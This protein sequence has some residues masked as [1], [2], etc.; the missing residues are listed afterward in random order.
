MVFGLRLTRRCAYDD[1]GFPRQVNAVSLEFAQALD[2]LIVRDFVRSRSADPDGQEGIVAELGVPHMKLKAG[3]WR[4]V[5]VWERQP[6]GVEIQDPDLTFPGVVWLVGA[7]V[8]KEGDADDAYRGFAR[9]GRAGLAPA[10]ADYEQLFAD[11][12]DAAYR[13]LLADLERAMNELLEAAWR[14]PHR[15]HEAVV[16]IGSVGVAILIWEAVEYRVVI[17]PLLD[18][19]HRPV[20]LEVLTLL[21]RVVFGD[22]CRLDE[23]E[24]ADAGVLAEIGYQPGRTEWA[25]AQLRQRKAT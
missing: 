13:A 11:I 1:L 22:D 19:E 12:E 4:G 9:L 7:G 23:L 15:L 21:A 25:V 6:R 16:E 18:L 8:R 24:D 20:S 17:L 3:R 2:L 14:E 10:D 5:T